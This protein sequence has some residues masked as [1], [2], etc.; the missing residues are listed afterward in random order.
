[1]LASYAELAFD[2]LGLY[3]DYPERT[4]RERLEAL[5]HE[6]LALDE[7]RALRATG[8]ALS[9]EDAIAFILCRP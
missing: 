2:R 8:A 7:L 5:L 9:L 1:M 3:C 4:T 6:R